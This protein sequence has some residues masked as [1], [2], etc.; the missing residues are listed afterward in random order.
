MKLRVMDIFSGIGGF[1]HAL[2][3][4]GGFETVAFCEID[5]SCQKVLRQHW[6]MV[7]IYSNVKT[8]PTLHNIDVIVGGFPCQDISLAGLQR[9]ITNE[10]RSGLWYEYKRLIKAHNPRWVIIENV[11][12]LINNGLLQV[13]KDLDEVGYDC[14]WQ[15]ISARDVGAPHLR[16][17][18]WIVAWPRNV[19]NVE[20]L[21]L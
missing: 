19:L 1:S 21:N 10:T 16:E 4:V 9:G 20:N 18:V 6:P 8:M 12:N 2:D 5:K 17:R 3:E 13:L 7:P 14:E 15:V 11:R